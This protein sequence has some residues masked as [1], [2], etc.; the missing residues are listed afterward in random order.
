MFL[1]LLLKNYCYWRNDVIAGKWRSHG[2]SDSL[3]T[4]HPGGCICASSSYASGEAIVMK[5]P[6]CNKSKQQKRTAYIYNAPKKS[7]VVCSSTGWFFVLQCC[8]GEQQDCC[9]DSSNSVDGMCCSKESSLVDTQTFNISF[10]LRILL[11]EPVEVRLQFALRNPP[12]DCKIWHMTVRRKQSEM[13]GATKNVILLLPVGPKLV[14]VHF[15]R[16][17]GNSWGFH[18]SWPPFVL[19][20]LHSTH[21]S[22]HLW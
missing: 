6:F 2:R 14:P 20:W 19:S 16:D 5:H 3:T 7:L 15:N 1:E 10:C 9:G 11:I 17:H 22:L 21:N 4:M 18:W 8:C 12:G 13:F